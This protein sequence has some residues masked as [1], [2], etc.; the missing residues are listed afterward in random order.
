MSEEFVKAIVN[1]MK[2]EFDSHDFIKEFIW[3]HPADYGQLLEKYDDV[4]IA[5]SQIGKF[6]QNHANTLGIVKTGDSG[7]DD[8]F[9]H[10][11]SCAKWRKL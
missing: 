1:D 10:A 4:R 5:H 2:D 9:G 6:L 8:I 11:T 7:T 3:K